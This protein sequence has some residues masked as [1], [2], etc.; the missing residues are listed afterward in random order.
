[1]YVKLTCLFPNISLETAAT[2]FFQSGAVGVGVT[3][4]SA[5]VFIPVTWSMGNSGGLQTILTNSYG[6][7]PVD[8]FPSGYD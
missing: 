8:D 1:M 6:K 7:C 5:T 4:A 3:S 2:P